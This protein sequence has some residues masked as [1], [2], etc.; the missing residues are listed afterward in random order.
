MS[1]SVEQVPMWL[2]LGKTG[3]ALRAVVPCGWFHTA[4]GTLTPNGQET[5]KLPT[6]ICGKC[7]KQLRNAHLEAPGRKT[8]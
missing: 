6:R 1:I 7:R 8:G 3:H 5:P 2:M 4:C